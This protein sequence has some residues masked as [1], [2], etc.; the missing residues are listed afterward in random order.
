MEKEECCMLRLD[1]GD[2]L[3]LREILWFAGSGSG[4]EI[5]SEW[6]DK[7]RRACRRA[8]T[9]HNVAVSECPDI[10]GTPNLAQHVVV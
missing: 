5:L 1:S 7:G 4:F 2:P 3:C 8:G 6:V 10:T 9:V